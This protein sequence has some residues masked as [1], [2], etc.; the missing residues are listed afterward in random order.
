MSGDFPR[1][2][3]R[4]WGHATV[5]RLARYLE[6]IE[7]RPVLPRTKPG[8]VLARIPAEAPEEAE[9]WE[10]IERDLDGLVEPNL[11]HWQHPGYLAYFAA[12]AS[13]PAILGEL[14][15]GGYDQVGILWRA[16]PVLTELEMG[17]VRWLVRLTGLPEEFDG[18]L[19]DT[20][21]TASP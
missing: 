3:L 21:S 13:T 4:E 14:L 9:P 5:E 6:T 7:S 12:C 8:E 10:A 19:A 2:T 16:S 18:Q 1:D 15:A 20:A 11:T 17:M